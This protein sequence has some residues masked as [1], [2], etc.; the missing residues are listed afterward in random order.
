LNFSSRCPIIIF[1]AI[2]DESDIISN[3]SAINIVR[4]NDGY[5]RVVAAK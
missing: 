2:S 4:S 3:G 5:V 1:Q